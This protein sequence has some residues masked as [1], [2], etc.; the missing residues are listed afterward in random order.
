[1]RLAWPPPVHLIA[2]ALISLLAL[3]LANLSPESVQETGSLLALGLV[4]LVPGYLI[5][6]FRFPAN[7]DLELSK[8]IIL[9]LGL[10]ALLAGL[11]SL[12]LMLTPRGL[13]PASLATILSLLAIFLNAISYIRFSTQP[14]KRGLVSRSR[15]RQS[16]HKDLIRHSWSSHPGPS[17]AYSLYSSGPRRGLI[18][19]RHRICRKPEPRFIRRRSHVAGGLLAKRSIEFAI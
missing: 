1:M 11:V 5:V 6:L 16:T 15:K 2:S 12:V 13:Q 7:R 18:C 8:R 17:P 9:C 19:R 4:I 3:A 10:S 14:R